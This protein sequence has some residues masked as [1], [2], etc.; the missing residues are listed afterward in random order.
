MPKQMDRPI[1][2]SLV[3]FEWE[4][5]SSLR[6][7]SRGEVPCWPLLLRLVHVA[8]TMT[9][10]NSIQTSHFHKN[11][12]QPHRE[13]LLQRSFLHLSYFPRYVQVQWFEVSFRLLF[14]RLVL[15]RLVERMMEVLIQGLGQDFVLE[16]I[17]CCKG[18]P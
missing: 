4:S 2:S 13:Q 6:L 5:S 10:S 8:V 9:I 16:Q 3:P 18:F 7:A 17:L 11:S 15:V 1:H 14:V 12:P